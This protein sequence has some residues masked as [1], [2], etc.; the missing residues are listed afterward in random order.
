M[1]DRYRFNY[2]ELTPPEQKMLRT[3]PWLRLQMEI[4]KGWK[5]RA[6]VRREPRRLYHLRNA[7]AELWL[8]VRIK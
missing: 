4:M 8:A 1:K 6:L 7:L 5:K 2:H 3:D